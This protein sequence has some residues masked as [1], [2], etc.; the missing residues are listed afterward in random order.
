MDKLD[1]KHNS[2]LSVNLELDGYSMH[3]GFRL[4]TVLEVESESAP[5]F[6]CTPF[7]CPRFP[8][9]MGSPSRQQATPFHLP[10]ASEP[11]FWALCCTSLEYA[12]SSYTLEL[13]WKRQS[14]LT[15]I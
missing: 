1:L 13:P 4:E 2:M 7:Q 12:E 5:M 15:K 14:E 11:K 9:A 6:C 10:S 8:G 3:G